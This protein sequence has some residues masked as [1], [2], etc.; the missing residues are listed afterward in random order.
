MLSTVFGQETGK[1]INN[2]LA[3]EPKFQEGYPRKIPW[4]SRIIFAQKN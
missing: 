2:L 1:M 3:A 4:R